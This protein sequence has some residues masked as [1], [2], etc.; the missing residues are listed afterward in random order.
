MNMC[1]VARKMP[2]YVCYNAA[3]TGFQRGELVRKPSSIEVYE[4]MG[5]CGTYYEI[6][7]FV[8][9]NTEWTTEDLVP[10][11]GKRV[12]AKEMILGHPCA[13]AAIIY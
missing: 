1:S 6:K 11:W 2:P 12:N 3:A 5:T 10:L 8:S 7:S 9:D 13:I 4:Y